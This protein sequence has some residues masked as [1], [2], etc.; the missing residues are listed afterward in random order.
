MGAERGRAV[1]GRVQCWQGKG[2]LGPPVWDLRVVSQQGADSGD[3]SPLISGEK[4]RK[5]VRGGEG[6]LLP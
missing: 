2:E 4:G 6:E 3:G 1:E 5:I